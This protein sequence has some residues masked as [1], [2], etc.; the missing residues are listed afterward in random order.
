M[1]LKEIEKFI[2]DISKIL[3]NIPDTIIRD[4]ILD[5]FDIPMFLNSKFDFDFLKHTHFQINAYLIQIKQLIF[6]DDKEKCDVIVNDLLCL[7]LLTDNLIKNQSDYKKAM[8]N[9]EKEYNGF[10]LNLKGEDN[11]IP[12]HN[13]IKIKRTTFIKL[14][15]KL[16]RDEKRIDNSAS[17]RKA[18]I[19]LFF[20]SKQDE[21]IKWNHSI[22]DL[23]RFFDLLIENNLITIPKYFNGL[24]VNNFLILNKQNNF[25]KF[26][27]KS[28]Q[29]S[30]EKNGYQSNHNNQY[31]HWELKIKEIKEKL[32]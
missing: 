2:E 12:L 18:I 6:S 16:I 3:Y 10:L 8:V 23:K 21:P 7:K 27:V 22:Y 29:T 32:R 24:I 25:Q 31:Q 15:Y 5:E 30:K 26:T 9:Y 19:S 11:Y 20:S 14:I 28:F 17:Q 1:D 13:S 4:Y